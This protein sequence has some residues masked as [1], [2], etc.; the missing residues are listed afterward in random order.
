MALPAT[1]TT[2]TFQKALV[3]AAASFQVIKALETHRP[4]LEEVLA[5]A[6]NPQQLATLG[7]AVGVDPLLIDRISRGRQPMPRQ[8]AARIALLAGLQQSE[9]EA[10][11]VDLTTDESP[12]AY[13]PVPP[14]RAWGDA[15]DFAPLARTL[16]YP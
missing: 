13:R 11:V 8:L 10:A 12:S 2:A 1:A 5:A 9:V 7:A 16:D 14:D 3:A 15:L 4:T 6:P